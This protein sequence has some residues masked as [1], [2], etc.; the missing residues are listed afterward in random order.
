MRRLVALTRVDRV[1]RAFKTTLYSEGEDKVKGR[2]LFLLVGSSN[3]E[4]CRRF[5][6]NAPCGSA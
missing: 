5:G 2:C 4:C 6:P 3:C 1:Y